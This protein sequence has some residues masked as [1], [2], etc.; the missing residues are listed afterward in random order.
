MP[1]PR[2][3]VNVPSQVI[4]LSTCRES[5]AAFGRSP[6]GMNPRACSGWPAIFEAALDCLGVQVDE[7]VFVGDNPEADIAGAQSIGMKAVLR[8]RHRTPPLIS[9]LIIPV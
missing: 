1:S 8:V 7:A 3:P 2:D 6:S 9:G 4:P 5:W